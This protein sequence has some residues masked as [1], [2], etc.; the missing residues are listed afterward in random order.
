[1]TDRHGQPKQFDYV[2]CQCAYTHPLRRFR[3]GF[4]GV[5]IVNEHVEE[6]SNGA[7]VAFKDKPTYAIRLGPIM[8]KPY[9]APRKEKNGSRP[10]NT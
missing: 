3:A 10:C 6:W 9:Y 8:G 4:L 2:E 7:G 1:M 5:S